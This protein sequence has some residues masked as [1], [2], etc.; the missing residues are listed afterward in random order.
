MTSVGQ[1]TE[2]EP[3]ITISGILLECKAG[4][5]DDNTGPNY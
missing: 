4:K 3:K 1:E 5:I 2:Q